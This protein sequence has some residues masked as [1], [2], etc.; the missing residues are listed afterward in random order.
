MDTTTDGVTDPTEGTPTEPSTEAQPAIPEGY[1]AIDLDT[2]VV[3]VIDGVEQE[4]TLGE[5]VKGYQR[6]ADYTRK[7][8]EAAQL[9]REAEAALKLD[10]ALKANPAETL[11]V[12]AEHY[13]VRLANEDNPYVESDFDEDPRL[14]QMQSRLDQVTAMLQQQQ[15]DR[16]VA[17][18]KSDFGENI[19][20]DAIE[21]HMFERRLPDLRSAAADLLIDDA[22]P[23][24]RQHAQRQQ[25]DKVIVGLK[26]QVAVANPG[27]GPSEPPTTV[28]DDERVSV[29]KAWELAKEGKTVRRW[30][31][32]DWKKKK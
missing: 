15:F 28:V 13:Q 21:Q 17:R 29:R 14:S 26:R 30:S 19:D 23:V 18:L 32:D 2:Q 31:A 25:Q 1:E 10:R 16:E 4:I 6:Q 12:L 20:V 7:T 3:V 27:S 11:R 9:K 8:Q 24:Y 5:A 22:L